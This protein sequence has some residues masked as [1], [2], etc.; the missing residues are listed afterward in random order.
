MS[1]CS[2]AI[3]I[4]HAPVQCGMTNE[5]Q[6]KYKVGGVGGEGWELHLGYGKEHLAQSLGEAG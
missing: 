1:G 5:T 2:A 6:A 3:R 4:S